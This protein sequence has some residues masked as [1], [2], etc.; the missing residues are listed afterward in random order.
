MPRPAPLLA[1]APPPAA[2]GPPARASRRAPG[3]ALLATLLATAALAALAG[4]D[5]AADATDLGPRP[6][7]S[8]DTGLDPGLD[9]RPGLD[10]GADST[11]DDGTPGPDATADATPD[12]TP[13][14]G[15]DATPDAGPVEPT[16]CQ[17]I[18]N[19]YGPAG[20][21]PITVEVIARGL[22]I[23]WGIGWLPD[24]DLIVTER[25]GALLRI[26][27]EGNNTRLADIPITDSGEG[28]LL[29]LALH[30]DFATTRAIYVYYTAGDRGDAHNVVERYIL[31]E[32]GQT[33]AA[34]RIIIDDIPAAQYH[35]GGRLRFGPDGHLYVGTGDAGNPN[36]AQDT[37]SLAGKILR[38]TDEGLVPPGNPY[39]GEA[40]WLYGIRNNQGFDWLED[41]RMVVTDHGP[42]GIP[43]EGGR[44]G[45][46]ELT[47]ASP[48][49]NLGWPTIYACE[50]R[51]GMLT[52]SMTWAN[53]MP[54]GGTAVYTGE[55][56]PEWRGDVFIGVLGFGDEIGHL[57]R[58][59][60][61]ANGDVE[62]SETYLRGDYGRMREVMM[63]PDGGL[64][65][66]TSGCDG[67]G[68][69]GQGDV[70]LRIGR[71]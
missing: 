57:H 3:A 61:A 35:D 58:I 26:D 60:L 8:L 9:M 52:P 63:G 64:Y 1:Y 49:D 62:L 40:T 6:D 31:A 69:C 42:S 23:P 11:T 50:E 18:A 34:D 14:A 12:A 68:S 2:P 30:P 33:A 48:G 43:N 47:V 25:T 55:E 67:R 39:P 46:D 45:H 54:P 7:A 20:D 32:D 27:A 22:D 17:L 65:V 19:G 44:R 4:C 37:T 21:T 15:P 38:V 66:T 24:G 53:A 56:I 28:G 5:D 29:G 36:S 71:R 59:R 41:G 13:D 51:E 70:I 10:G 16:T